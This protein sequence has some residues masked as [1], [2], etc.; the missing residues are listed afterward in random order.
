MAVTPCQ[1]PYAHNILP[2]KLSELKN[3]E[4]H[5]LLRT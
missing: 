2:V 4:A 1:Y 3:Y 5:S